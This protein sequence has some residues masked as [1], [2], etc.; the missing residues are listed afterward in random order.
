MLSNGRTSL[1]LC[2][3][4]RE[5]EAIHTEADAERRPV[6]GYVLNIVMRNIAAIERIG[7]S[8][9]L[10]NLPVPRIPTPHPRT[11]MLIRCTEEESQK[12]RR[13]AERTGMSIS[14]LILQVL[15]RS[16]NLKKAHVGFFAPPDTQKT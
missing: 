14:G 6:S 9:R 8:H 16:W 1:F 7:H 12:I 13:A 10:L 4:K 11:A 2:C 5:A 3:S 15:H